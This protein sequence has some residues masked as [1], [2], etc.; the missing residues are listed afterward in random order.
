[1]ERQCRKVYTLNS[2]IRIN[3]WCFLGFFKAQIEKSD[4]PYN[5]IKAEEY[6]SGTRTA[7][8]ID[9]LEENL[10]DHEQRITQMNTS[11]EKLLDSYLRLT[12]LRHVLNESSVFFE[13]VTNTT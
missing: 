1:M 12:E 11:Y 2:W 8:I 13:Q 3:F 6:P 10:K 9:D 4:I 5:D 7:Q